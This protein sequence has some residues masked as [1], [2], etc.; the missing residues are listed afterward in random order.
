M[1]AV[2][3]LRLFDALRVDFASIVINHD[4]MQPHCFEEARELLHPRTLRG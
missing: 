3:T 1:P 4:E 2:N